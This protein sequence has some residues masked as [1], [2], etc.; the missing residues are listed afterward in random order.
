MTECSAVLVVRVWTETAS[1]TVRARLLDASGTSASQPV[2]VV[3]AAGVDEICAA[4]REWIDQL[5]GGDGA[6]TAG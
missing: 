2:N 6:V 4:I 5:V 1:P 3:A